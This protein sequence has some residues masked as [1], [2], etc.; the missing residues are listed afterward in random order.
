VI[1]LND[2]SNPARGRRRTTRRFAFVAVLAVVL[3]VAAMV[4]PRPRV[5]VGFRPVS[6]DADPAAAIAAAEAAIGVP[7]AVASRVVWHDDAR[8][9]RTPL[10]VVMLHGFSASPQETLPLSETVAQKLGANLFLP[11]L[12]GH[13]LGSE[14]LG[15]A[16]ADAWVEDA[17]Q[18]VAVGAAIGERV[19]LMGVSTG[20]TLALLLGARPEWR[21]RIAAL[22]LISPNLGPHAA[23]AE[24]LAG[25][26]AEQIA[27]LATGGENAFEPT[28]TDHAR[29]W[30]T[31]YPSRV[32]PQMMALVVAV[33]ALEARWL[34]RPALVYYAPGDRVVR[35]ELVASAC[36]R[37]RAWTCHAVTD[38]GDPSQHVLAGRILSPDTT[39]RLANDI[40]SY[41]AAGTASTGRAVTPPTAAE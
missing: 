39:E 9:T 23:G 34:D 8:H 3:L 11:R 13:G 1:R 21:D 10:A 33:R 30:T 35:S 26:W 15:A 12:S 14:A 18:A 4:G 38:S 20:G 19:V 27:W 22:V 16:T 5:D 25:P 28:N 7:A 41:V 24:L 17:D 29:Y 31:R 40:A 32:L 36:A 6:V 37:A 2:P